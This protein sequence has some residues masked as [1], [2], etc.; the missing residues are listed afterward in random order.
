MYTVLALV[1]IFKCCCFP[2]PLTYVCTKL[3][4]FLNGAF[5]QRDQSNISLEFSFIMLK[6][7]VDI[8]HVDFIVTECLLYMFYCNN[9]K[10]ILQRF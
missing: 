1:L 2:G 9:H 6:Q 10:K 4:V 8:D 5:N 7:T 3:T